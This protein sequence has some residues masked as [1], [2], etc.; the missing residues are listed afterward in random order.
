MFKRQRL[1]PALEYMLN[2]LSE[3]SKNIT[4]FHSDVPLST[5]GSVNQLFSVA[6]HLTNFQ[7]PL[8]LG[9]SDKQNL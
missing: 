5:L 6:C 7:G 3:G 4:F 8:I 2:G 9:D 1:L